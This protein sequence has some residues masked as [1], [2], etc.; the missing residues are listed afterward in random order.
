MFNFREEFSIYG[1]VTSV[2]DRPNVLP[3]WRGVMLR[4]LVELYIS[5]FV[6]V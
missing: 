1:E 6:I 2:T 3:Y 5:V 4:R